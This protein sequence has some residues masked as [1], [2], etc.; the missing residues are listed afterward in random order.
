MPNPPEWARGIEEIA[1][2]VYVD[3]DQAMHLDT[4]RLCEAHGYPPTQANQDAIAR[5]ARELF[6]RE[7]R[8]KP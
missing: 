5:A 1:P 6:A 8:I 7:S 4:A 2:G 3:A